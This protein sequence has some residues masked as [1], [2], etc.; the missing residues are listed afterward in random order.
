MYLQKTALVGAAF[1]IRQKKEDDMNLS[2]RPPE[3]LTYVGF[4]QS[5]N[6]EHRKNNGND[7]RYA[8]FKI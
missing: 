1:V 2:L 3:N 8:C 7:Q 4:T 6:A 5:N